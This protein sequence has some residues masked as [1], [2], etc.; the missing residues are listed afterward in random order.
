MNDGLS[1]ADA[2]PVAL[3]ELRDQLLVGFGGALGLVV[4][5]YGIP[6]SER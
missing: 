6:V 3:R 4:L 1:Q 2:L 5:A